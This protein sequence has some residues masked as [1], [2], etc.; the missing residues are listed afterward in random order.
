M[1]FLHTSSDCCF[2]PEPSLQEWSKI[3]WISQYFNISPKCKSEARMKW[4]FLLQTTP[5][6]IVFC[7]ISCSCTIHHGVCNFDCIWIKYVSQQNHFD[8]QGWHPR[9]VIR[10]YYIQPQDRA[11]NKSCFKTISVPW[12]EWKLAI[13]LH[14]IQCITPTI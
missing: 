13:L 5:S 2:I 7:Q 6:N 3:F 9:E 10:W 1:N 4:D 14:V 12:I 11:H 8:E